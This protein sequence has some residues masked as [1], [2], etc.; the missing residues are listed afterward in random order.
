V[1]PY[2]IWIGSYYHMSGG[3]RALHVLRDELMKRGVEAWMSYEKHDPNAIGVYPEIVS[4][5][6]NNYEKVVRWLLN[7]ASLPPDPTWAWESGMGD[8]P[9]LTV[10]IIEMDLWRPEN[11]ST[12]GPGRGCAYWV[13]K[14]VK[15]ERFIPDKAVEISRSNFSTRKELAEFIGGL[16]YLISFDPFT[17]VVLE[18]VMIG[19][20][21]LIRG[22]HPNLSRQQI[23]S[24]GWTPFGVA[25]G[26]EELE[27]ARREVHLAY[28]HYESLLPKF[29]QRIDNFVE[30]TQQ[31]FF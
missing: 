8:Y 14:G 7:T 26:M 9:L 24:H 25:W 17:A 19:T 1:K 20:P 31:K 30:Q 28:P 29:A 11:R 2:E 5:N 21:V 3:I 10:N 12:P 16:N 27:D 23:I 6:P 13:G 15:D 4:D 18:S 22:D